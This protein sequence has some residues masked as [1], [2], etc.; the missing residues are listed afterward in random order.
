[1]LGIVSGLRNSQTHK[2]V[3]TWGWGAEGRVCI[4][5]TDKEGERLF[6]LVRF[7]YIL[8]VLLF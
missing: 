4:E 7:S 6:Y 1:M 8:K 5:G 3:P 2:P